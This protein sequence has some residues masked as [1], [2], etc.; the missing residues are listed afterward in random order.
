M[1][2]S[3]Q[4]IRTHRQWRASTGL[5]ESQFHD[6]VDSFSQA[7]EEMFGEN[8]TDRQSKSSQEAIFQS[9]EDLLFFCLYSLKSGLTYDLLG[10]SFDLSPSNAHANQ[11]M[12]I[13]VL[14]LALEHRGFMPKREY[15]SD[16]EFARH[17]NQESD[18]MIDGTEQ[19]R[20][21]PVDQEEQ[22]KDYSGKKKP[23]R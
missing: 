11:A 2:V 9:Y 21:R 10:L 16:E 20:Q 15:L 23:T 6:L 14:Q 22:K 12:A 8:I 7:Y 13:N 5:T 4:S 19:R 3:Y 1:A 17:W 18:I